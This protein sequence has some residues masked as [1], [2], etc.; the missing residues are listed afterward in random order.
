MYIS[1]LV[2]R[3]TT[4]A[5]EE[6]VAQLLEYARDMAIAHTDQRIKDCVITV[7]PFFNQ[8]ERRAILSAAELAGLK[9]TIYE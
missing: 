4:Y 7:P 5:V 1:F 9:V 2:N 6:L 3:E 8:A